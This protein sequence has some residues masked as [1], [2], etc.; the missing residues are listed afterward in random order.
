[1]SSYYSASVCHKS[2]AIDMHS[3]PFKV[4]DVFI[5]GPPNGPVLFCLL[6]FVVCRRRLSSSV[7]LPA[8]V[9]A[10]GAW[11]VWW[12]TLHGGPVRLRP[13]RATPCFFAITTERYQHHETEAG[14]DRR[15]PNTIIA[16][17][18]WVPN[19]MLHSALSEGKK[20]PKLP[21]PLG[22]SSPRRRRIEP[23][24]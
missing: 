20:P 2:A 17:F 19:A 8:G 23:R 15:R 9:P 10:A 1:M 14:P 11:A 12:L 7:M 16:V 24:P 13:V 3:A 5:T 21:L 22:I 6:A 18:V 4:E